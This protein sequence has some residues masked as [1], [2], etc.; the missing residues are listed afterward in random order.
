[1][2]AGCRSA[3][4]GCVD[5]KGKLADNMLAHFADYTRRRAELIASPGRV[6]EILEQ[7]AAKARAIAQRTM[8]DVH[9]KLGLW[10][11]R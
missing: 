6:Q 10:R 4:I 1:M 7:G 11:S 8:A 5:C 3:S 9:K 2:Y